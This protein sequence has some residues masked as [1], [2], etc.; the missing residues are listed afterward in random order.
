MTFQ[1]KAFRKGEKSKCNR[2]HLSNTDGSKLHLAVV[3]VKNCSTLAF[4]SFKSS[5]KPIT[6]Q[7]T[8]AKEIFKNRTKFSISFDYRYLTSV[9]VTTFSRGSSRVLNFVSILPFKSQ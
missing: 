1:T 4:K 7:K 9:L 2:S 3:S 6:F 8:L 5:K